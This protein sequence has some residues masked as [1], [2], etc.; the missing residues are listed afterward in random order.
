MTTRTSFGTAALTQGSSFFWGYD[1]SGDFVD[2]YGSASNG[3][4]STLG[5]IAGSSSDQITYT[6]A[7]ASPS[8]I[9]S[10]GTAI[11]AIPEPSSLALF[12]LGAAGLLRRRR[13]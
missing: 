12:A 7:S 3:V 6:S 10:P 2:P 13:D 5:T 1:A 8:N 4:V 9:A 11:N